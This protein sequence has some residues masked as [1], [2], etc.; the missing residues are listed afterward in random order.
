MQFGF[1]PVQESKCIQNEVW[2]MLGNIFN[3][4]F[5]NIFSYSWIEA[6]KMCTNMKNYPI[7]K[8]HIRGVDILN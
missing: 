2:S 6:S 7:E 3:K 5:T 8:S 4:L 1:F